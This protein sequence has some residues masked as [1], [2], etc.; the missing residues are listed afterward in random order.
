MIVYIKPIFLIICVLISFICFAGTNRSEFVISEQMKKEYII[1]RALGKAVISWLADGNEPAALECDKLIDSLLAAGEPTVR[2]YFIA[3]QIANLR[4]KPKEAITA[5][6]NALRKYP[7][8]RAPGLSFPV[9]IVAPLWI[10]T[11]ARQTGDFTKAQ[12]IYE[13]ILGDL[14]DLKGK[15]TLTMICH[16]YL[17][18]IESD[19]LQR[20][21][22]ALKRLNVL[23]RIPRPADKNWADWHDMYRAWAKYKY[24]KISYGKE[25]A[26]QKLTA[27]KEASSTIARVVTQLKLCGIIASPLSGCCGNDKR[28]EVIGKTIFD[29]I[30]QSGKSS[31]DEDL[32][33]LTYGYVYQQNKK[34]DEAEKYFLQIYNDNIFFSP[35]AGIYLAFTEKDQGKTKEADEILEQVKTKYPGYN[36][37]VT[38]V[39]QSWK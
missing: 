38:K 28:A 27:H 14:D 18:E 10:G 39:R 33:K 37:L 12:K 26:I 6:E 17:A 7:D 5:L 21:T 20:N 4:H 31:I 1:K 11:I 22:D 2:S 35:V 23:E 29:R 34:Y 36:S 15:E 13:S 16:L 19:Y 3:A 8:E 30:I 25:Q 32:V 24:N 9:K